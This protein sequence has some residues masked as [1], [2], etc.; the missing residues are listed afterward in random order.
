VAGPAD[1]QDAPAPWMRQQPLHRRCAWPKRCL[2]LT[3]C[4]V[5]MIPSC[6][7]ACRSP[8]ASASTAR[9]RPST[10]RSASGRTARPSPYKFR[11]MVHDAD[12]MPHEVPRRPQA[13]QAV[14]ALPQSEGRSPHHEGRRLPA[15]DGPRR[16]APDGERAS[17]GRWALWHPVPSSGMRSCGMGGPM[18]RT[19]G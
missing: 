6:R 14:A 8:R 18:V 2:D 11:T 10:A 4:L 19:A 13:R 3:I 12:R 5:A 15:Q 7:F 9:G 17:G 16:A 1:H